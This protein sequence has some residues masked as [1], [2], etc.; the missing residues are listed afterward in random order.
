MIRK[1][2]SNVLVVSLLL[3]LVVN[4]VSFAPKVNAATLKAGEYAGDYVL[5]ELLVKF[6]NGSS[7]DALFLTKHNLSAPKKISDDLYLV[8]INNGVDILTLAKTITTNSG[9]K[10]AEPNFIYTVQSL[11][12]PVDRYFH[13]QWGLEN[14]NFLGSQD[15]DIKA[16]EAWNTSYGTGQV[17]KVA[18]IDTGIKHDHPDLIGRVLEGKNFIDGQ[19]SLS[20][21][22]NDG[23]GTQ[24]AGVIGANR[25]NVGITG[26]NSSVQLYALKAF[27][28]V[29]NEISSIPTGQ[30]DDII[31]AIDYAASQ[32]IKL[33]N[34]SW[35]TYSF[36]Q[37]LLDTMRKYQNILFVT[38]AG[39]DLPNIPTPIPY[40]NID[41]YNNNDINPY[42]PSSYDL[43]NIISVT[44]S[45]HFDALRGNY[46]VKSVDLAAPGFDIFTT[47]RVPPPFPPDNTQPR[48]FTGCST[49]RTPEGDDDMYRCV[50]GTS[51]AAAHVTG[52]A[53]LYWG[54]D[55]DK[56]N[57]DIKFDIIASAD[58]AFSLVG[59]TLTGGRLNLYNLINNNFTSVV[60]NPNIPRL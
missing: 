46:G 42:Y 1:L 12:E 25:N 6:K 17:F 23:H 32:N 14:K 37:S 30:A 56:S 13:M 21:M 52:A 40:N 20:A 27:A 31:E 47:D 36:S 33:I 4:T 58:K 18:I 54:K 29:P 59:T 19:E 5:G 8:K 39:N 48:F 45:N 57:S 7:P 55:P 50:G 26:I 44:S 34:M 35:G 11:I 51:V 43:P 28:S 22:D 2:L 60:V 24:V 15:T 9:V 38:S 41:H 10:Y 53:S 3:T 49:Y 16:V